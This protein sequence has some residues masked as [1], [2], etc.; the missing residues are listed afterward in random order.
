M[1]LIVMMIVVIISTCSPPPSHLDLHYLSP[2]HHRRRWNY[3]GGDDGDG[4]NK[5]NRGAWWC[6]LKLKIKA[7]LM[8]MMILTQMQ[9]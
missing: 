7:P 8:I 5:D 9:W 1:I 3:D 2:R 4:D 6:S